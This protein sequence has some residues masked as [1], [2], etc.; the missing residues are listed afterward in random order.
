MCTHTHTHFLPSITIYL[1]CVFISVGIETENGRRCENTTAALAHS[2]DKNTHRCVVSHSQ[3]HTMNSYFGLIL[4]NINSKSHS[5]QMSVYVLYNFQSGINL[6][7]FTVAV[8]RLCSCAFFVCFDFIAKNWE[9]VRRARLS[10][11]NGKMKPIKQ[12]RNIPV[13]PF[14]LFSLSIV[15]S[16]HKMHNQFYHN[17]TSNLIW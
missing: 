14:C 5:K 10:C 16:I 4:I 3:T 12:I 13:G 17:M 9:N 15:L 8:F 7:L 6:F 1:H 2:I 11:C